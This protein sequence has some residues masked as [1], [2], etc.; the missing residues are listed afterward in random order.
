MEA[1]CGQLGF[2]NICDDKTWDITIKKLVSLGWPRTVGRCGQDRAQSWHFKGSLHVPMN[3][4]WSRV[5]KGYLVQLGGHFMYVLRVRRKGGGPQTA[6]KCI[7]SLSHRHPNDFL[8]EQHIFRQ[9]HPSCQH[10]IDQLPLPRQTY[11]TPP[12]PLHQTWPISQP[13]TYMN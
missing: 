11:R 7:T 5:G 10:Q 8:R 1:C 9:L 6:R 4:E 3:D 13:V 12:H 2:F